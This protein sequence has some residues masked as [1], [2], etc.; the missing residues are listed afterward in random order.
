ML[1]GLAQQLVE[2]MAPYLAHTST[3]LLSPDEAAATIEHFANCDIVAANEKVVLIAPF[4][5]ED[6]SNRWT[7][8]QLDADVQALWADPVISS[9]AAGLLKLYRTQKEALIHND[10]HAGNLLV[11]GDSLYL[12]DWEFA[13]YGPIAFDIGCLLGNLALAVLALQGMEQ[14]E[15]QQEQLRLEQQHLSQLDEQEQQRQ[16]LPSRH[17]SSSLQQQ[18]QHHSQGTTPV[19]TDTSLLGH[20]QNTSNMAAEGAAGMRSEDD[21]QAARATAAAAT[22]RKRAKRSAS[23]K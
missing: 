1:P 2:L 6:S 8:P 14:F 15:R 21:K 23:A 20:S 3:A 7:S 12:I 16:Q 22:S 9:T 11:A 4:T 17:N 19:S 13:T 10:L 5:P 18:Q